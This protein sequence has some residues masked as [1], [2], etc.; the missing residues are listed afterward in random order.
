[1]LAFRN[2]ALFIVLLTLSGSPASLRAMHSFDYDINHL[3]DL[4]KALHDFKVEHIE[5][6]SQ[7][8]AESN[9]VIKR[10]GVV[11]K[12]P[13]AVGTVILCHGYQ[14][15]KDDAIFFR[16]LFPKLN[17]VAVDFRAHGEQ[18]QGQYSTL[19]RDEAFDVISVARYVKSRKDLNH[20]PLLVYGFSM[21]AV[22]A[23]EAQAQEKMFDAMILDCPYDSTDA[24]M[25]RHL[26]NQKITLFGRKFS[27]PF[28]QTIK[29]YMYDDRLRPLM[30]M[31]FKILVGF[32]PNKVET[33][34]VRVRPIDSIKKT[35]VPVLFILCEK[36]KKVPVVAIKKLY[37]AKPG[38]KRLWITRG[39]KHFDSYVSQPELYFYKVNKF[40]TKFLHDKLGQTRPEKISDD[41][42]FMRRAE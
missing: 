9:S 15:N 7:Q 32:D 1:M 17:A 36:D 39:R 23:I 27:I 14:A 3:S 22:A 30:K 19:G 29:K 5:V 4:K 21:G 8:E 13:G 11:I 26:A 18:R 20:G 42:V 16:G 33:R 28:A 34:F 25:S 40:V 2:F 6:E 41:R 38:Y 35:D 37:E 24:A 12:R 10:K 31:V